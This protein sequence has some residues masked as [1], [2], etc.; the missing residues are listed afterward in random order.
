MGK[1][2]VPRYFAPVAVRWYVMANRGE[3]VFFAEGE[4][5]GFHFVDR[6][7]NPRGLRSAREL[8]SDDVGRGFASASTTIHHA[9]GDRKARFDEV[10]RQFA[11]QVTRFLQIGLDEKRFNELVLIA[12]PQFLGRLRAQLNA[13]LR[14]VVVGEIP[15]DFGQGTD[16]D[17]RDALAEARAWGS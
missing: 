7:V 11:R 3:A 17:I 2:V 13:N 6:L 1:I 5:R 4:G 10:A 8:N 12:E 16:S 15:R 9:V 14:D